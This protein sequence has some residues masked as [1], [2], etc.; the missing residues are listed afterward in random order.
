MT[1]R[2][3]RSS[4]RNLSASARRVRRCS[5]RAVCAS[6]G[7]TS[8]TPTPCSASRRR[9]GATTMALRVPAAH[10]RRP[11]PTV[12]PFRPVPRG[13]GRCFRTSRRLTEAASSALC[14]QDLA[15]PCCQAC[16]H[17]CDGA[18]RALWQ[19]FP[20]RTTFVVRPHYF[21]L[22][23]PQLYIAPNSEPICLHFMLA[24]TNYTHWGGKV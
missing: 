7:W 2:H 14:S 9:N 20:G 10:R 24:Q 22:P 11:L 18:G 23:P 21:C 3:W 17:G 5:C 6:V 15:T 1:T 8:S 4:L 13:T 19:R 16:T 12:R